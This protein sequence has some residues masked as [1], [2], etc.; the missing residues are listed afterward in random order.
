[1]LSAQNN[2]LTTGAG[3]VLT[4][5][6]LND[7]LRDAYSCFVRCEMFFFNWPFRIRTRKSALICFHLTS[8]VSD[9]AIYADTV[10]VFL[11]TKLQKKLYEGELAQQKHQ[12]LVFCLPATQIRLCALETSF[13]KVLPDLKTP[14]WRFRLNGQTKNENR[15][16]RKTKRQS[17]LNSMTN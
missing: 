17:F 16:L 13:S 1:M 6:K 5:C 15:S 8:I 2:P 7:S 9:L 3:R 4:T 10:R 14:H 12:F 11:I